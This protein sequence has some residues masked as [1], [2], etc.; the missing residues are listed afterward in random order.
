MLKIIENPVLY[1]SHEFYTKLR[2]CSRNLIIIYACFF[3]TGRL[4]DIMAAETTGQT[5]CTRLLDSLLEYETAT[6]VQI[7][8]RTVGLINRI[9]QLFIITYIVALV[10][11]CWYIDTRYGG[12]CYCCSM[13]SYQ[14]CCYL[15]SYLWRSNRLLRR[16]QKS[17]TKPESSKR[18][19]VNSSHKNRTVV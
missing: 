8:N 12:Q 3:H 1:F 9:L 6:V 7:P 11:V 14:H 16:N 15:R 19:A 13:P 17:Q 5:R 18:K 2:H 4:S 10:V